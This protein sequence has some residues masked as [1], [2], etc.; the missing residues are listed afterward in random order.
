[1]VYYSKY[2]KIITSNSSYIFVPN[3]LDKPQKGELHRQS[4]VSDGE[5]AIKGDNKDETSKGFHSESKH[6]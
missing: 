5:T 4:S 6:I 1:M 3:I 2:C